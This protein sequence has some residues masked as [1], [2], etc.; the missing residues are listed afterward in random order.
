MIFYAYQEKIKG[1]IINI[2]HFHNKT[3]KFMYYSINI[4]KSLH[5]KGSVVI[6]YSKTSDYFNVH[7][8]TFIIVVSI[9]VSEGTAIP[10][11]NNKNNTVIITNKIRRFISSD[12]FISQAPF[13]CVVSN[14]LY[15]STYFINTIFREKSDNFLGVH[16]TCK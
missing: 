8:Y 16:K 4:F 1:R 7:N 11:R 10:V 2:L 14:H 12:R 13:D 9:F 15:S 3:H 6:Y 5:I